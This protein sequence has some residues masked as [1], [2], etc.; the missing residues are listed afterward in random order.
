[1]IKSSSLRGAACVTLVS[2]ALV[3]TACGGGG[4][5]GGSTSVASSDTGPVTSP[6]AGAVTVPVTSTDTG[7]L[8]TPASTVTVAQYQ[9]LRNASV[10]GSAVAPDASQQTALRADDIALA[11]SDMRQQLVGDGNLVVLPPLNHASLR[12]LGAAARGDSLAQLTAH[13]DLAP[14]PVAAAW[15]TGAVVSAGWV[16]QGFKLTKTFLAATDSSAGRLAGWSLAESGFADGSNYADASLNLAVSNTGVSLR[17]DAY[18]RLALLHSLSLSAAWSGATAFDG[19]F[20]RSVH[21]Q[22]SVSLLRLTAG[23]TRITGTDYVADLLAAGD[24][25]LLSLRPTADS[26]TAFAAGRL[27]PAM[28]EAVQ[29][30]LAAG[31]GAAGEM[32]LPAGGLSLY[33][34]VDAAI[35]RAGATQVFDEVFANLRGLDEAGGTYAVA[36]APPAHLS[37]AAGGLD[38]NAAHGLSFVFSPSNVNGSV[39]HGG[40]F[41]WVNFPFT[42][43]ICVVGTAPT[44]PVADLRSLFLVLLDRRGAVLAL[45][46]IQTPEGTAYVPI[47]V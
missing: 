18:T 17:R 9:V 4:E 36:S 20:E 35:N 44:W 7:A 43:T 25:R 34:S 29:T 8:V 39:S 27:A 33:T 31:G 40:V 23:V 41:S 5:G 14:T 38:L 2:A 26:L 32:L 13:F 11:V 28:A 46:A 12:A 19:I 37:I 3:M 21:D 22:F 42:G 24:L 47:C 1:M 15:Q 16:A 45:T 30:L 10:E 6:V